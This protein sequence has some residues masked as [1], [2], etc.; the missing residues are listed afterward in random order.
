MGVIAERRRI[1]ARRGDVR[2]PIA[3]WA[4]RLDRAIGAELL[5]LIGLTVVVL[6]PG[7]RIVTNNGTLDVALNTLAA[8]AAAGAAALAWIRYRID[9]EVAAL[10]ETSAFLVLCMSRAMVVGIAAL[11]TSDEL[12]M[13]LDRAQQWPLYAW[14]LARLVTGILLV[15]AAE[16]SLRGWRQRGASVAAIAFAPTAVLVAVFVV[17]RAVEPAL[18]LLFGPSG[19]AALGG[20][21]AA[22]PGMDTLGLAMQ[23]TIGIVYVRGAQLYRRVYL[24]RG[25]AYAAWVTI[26]LVLAAV[27]QIH[28]AMFPGIYRPVVVVDDALRALFSLMLLLGIEAQ[29]RG[30]LGD[31]RTANARLRAL[32]TADVE[33]AALAAQARVARDVH[34]GLSQELWLAKLKHGRLTKLDDLPAAAA[35]DLGDLGDAVDRALGHA[36]TVIETMRPGAPA[37]SLQDSVRDLVEEFER[38]TGIAVEVALDDL[39]DASLTPSRSRAVATELL[40]IV[41]EALANVRKHADATVVRV[42]GATSAGDGGI[43][44]HVVDNGRGFEPSDVGR[45]AYGVRGMQE[46]AALI[47]GSV[48]VRSHHA[49]GTIVVIRVPGLLGNGDDPIS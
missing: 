33:R 19:V 15:L 14:S 4:T 12:G 49:D 9:R 17:L 34:D 10:Y 16:A 26:A 38:R 25:Q 20:D 35:Q 21:R 3:P 23:A 28:W 36:R 13:T 39:T 11:G 32:R 29:F 18:P 2:A 42:S 41:G 1:P 22:M 8:I 5:L 6:W 44:I 48:D 46:R 45:A 31:L 43:E 37:R 40:P 47:G 7:Q 30:D 24:R 27:S